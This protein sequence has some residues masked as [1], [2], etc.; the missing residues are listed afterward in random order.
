M[1]NH[2]MGHSLVAARQMDSAP[3]HNITV[4]P[5]TSGALGYTMQVDE[6]EPVLLSRDGALNKI[7]TL[8]GGRAAEEVVFQS[9]TTGA[10]NDI[11]QATRIARAMVTRYG[12][13]EEFGMVALETQINPYLSDE[14]SMVCSSGTAEKVDHEVMKIIAQAHDRARTILQ[15]NLAK[16]H[17]IAA[18][19]LQQETISGEEFM[20]LLKTESTVTV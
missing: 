8:T 5:R 1:A 3:V 16:L 15:E 9:V 13:S 10:A 6:P 14:T 19:L 2:A 11:E 17:E 18:V 7:A 4:V 12:M 20:H